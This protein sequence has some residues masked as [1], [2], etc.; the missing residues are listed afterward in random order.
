[1]WL[2]RSLIS[3]SVKGGSVWYLF[4]KT[5]HIVAI[6]SWMAGVLYL[7]RILVNIVDH[8]NKGPE[9]SEVLTGMALR[10][11]K[12]ITMPAMGASYILGVWMLLLQ[13]EWLKVGAMHAKLTLVVL[14]TASTVYAGRLA[15]TIAAGERLQKTSKSLRILNE[16]PTLLMILIVAM[17]VMRP[18]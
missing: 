13:P 9:V 8:A 15:K 18:F 5:L 14:L 4:L 12:I 3:S 1:M 10:L 16:V 17:I 7:Y 2:G 11:Y 6:I